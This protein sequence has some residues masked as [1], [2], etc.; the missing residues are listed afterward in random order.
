M[1]DAARVREAEQKLQET[2]AACREA[3]RAV[4][5]VVTLGS[6]SRDVVRLARERAV[7]LIVMGVEGPHAVH[8]MFFGSTTH[9]VVRDAPCAVLAVRRT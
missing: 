2:V 7:D 9:R 5:T 8:R 6:A 1:P 4:E 3:G